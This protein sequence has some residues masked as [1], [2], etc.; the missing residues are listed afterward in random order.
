[1]KGI[2]MNTDTG[3]IYNPKQMKAVE[4]AINEGFE[5][6]SKRVKEAFEALQAGKV[7]PMEL[8]PTL[9]Q[10]LTRKI[11]RNNPCPCGSG[12]KFK[13]CCYTGC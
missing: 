4:Q 5:P 12:R 2:E 11:G 10:R 1:L 8:E 13:K 9:L 7:K 3:R 6:T